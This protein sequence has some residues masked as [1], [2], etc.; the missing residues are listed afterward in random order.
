MNDNYI[1]S[2]S[3]RFLVGCFIYSKESA[4]MLQSIVYYRYYYTVL[5]YNSNID[6]YIWSTYRLLSMLVLLAGGS[7]YQA[8]PYV[9]KKVKGFVMDPH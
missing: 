3:V 2:N 1:Y 8:V 5:C 4:H 9:Y 7:I 6:C